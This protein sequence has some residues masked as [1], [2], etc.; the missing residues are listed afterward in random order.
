MPRWWG[1]GWWGGGDP[2]CKE[3]QRQGQGEEGFSLS[4]DSPDVGY[5]EGWGDGDGNV[6]N[7]GDTA[8]VGD[9]GEMIKGQSLRGI[10]SISLHNIMCFHAFFMCLTPLYSSVHSSD[11]GF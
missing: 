6:G 9:L 10:L 2:G 1:E 8:Y 11:I 4:T 3:H 5:S 7:V